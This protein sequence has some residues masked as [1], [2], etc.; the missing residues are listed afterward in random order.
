MTI[1]NSITE[2]ARA[3]VAQAAD[4][5]IRQISDAL[6]RHLHAFIREV[7]PSQAEWKAGIDFLTRTGHMCDNLRQ[8]FILLSDVLGVSMLVD[9]INHRQDRG[10]TQSTVLGPFYVD[11]PPEMPAGADIAAGLP[12]APLLVE[13]RVTDAA[14]NALAGA[15]VDT[16]QA[17]EAGFYDVQ[18]L[19][20][21]GGLSG[22][23]RFRTDAE[24]RFHFWTVKP[25][26]YPIPD[27]GPVGD[28]L[29]AQGRHPWR[30]AHV[31][32][33]IAAPG[34][35][36]LVTH[37]F[38]AGDR[39]LDSDVVFGVKPQLIARIEHCPAG[40]APDGRAMAQ[41]YHRL[42]YDFALAPEKGD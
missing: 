13:G 30:P 17:D 23:A 14:G 36:T 38:E 33:M 28:L 20:R 2:A 40:D 18:Q 1:E 5:R 32:F 26:S 35:A 39:Y 29:K 25:S 31:H 12:G 24:G 19:D 34:H 4:D 21:L 9:A 37:V 11:N 16:W 42:R 3:R 22:R 41:P 10:A 6:V 27:D 7:E 15:I 8:E